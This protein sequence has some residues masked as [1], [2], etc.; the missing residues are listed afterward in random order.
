MGHDRAIDLLSE[1]DNTNAWSSLNYAHLVQLSVDG[2][3]VD[4]S[5]YN[6]LEEKLQ[7]DYDTNLLHVGSCGLHTVHGAFWQGIMCT[8]WSISETLTSLTRLF[9][10]TP[11][12]KDDHISVTKSTDFPL[13]YC[14][15]RWVE[16]IIVVERA[17]T[18]YPSVKTYVKGRSR[19]TS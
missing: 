9:K 5:L 2:P 17:K 3:N 4:W 6:K 12:R 13:R 18:I 16:N 1:F 11:A 8:K 14:P 15:T 19:E 10:D 7:S